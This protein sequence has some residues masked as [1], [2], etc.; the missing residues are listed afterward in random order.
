MHTE[1]SNL[2]EHLD[3]YRAVTLQ[4][5]DAAPDDAALDWRPVPE[6]FSLGQQ[7]A[8]VAQ[9]EDY[10]TRGLF[11]GEWRPELLRFDAAPRGRAGG[12]LDRWY[13]DAGGP[14][15]VWRDLAAEV[16]GRPL[17]GGH[18]FPEQNA[19]ETVA[20]LRAFFGAD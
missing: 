10:Y 18:F 1:L 2:R 20:E 8:H 3:R 19:A 16:S 13:D 4:T 17:A 12:A 11:G 9:T 6:A 14:L 5:I 7:L 15:G